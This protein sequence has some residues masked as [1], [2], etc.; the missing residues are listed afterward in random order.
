[1]QKIIDADN[2]ADAAA[3]ITP[4]RRI[5]AEKEVFNLDE[6]RANASRFPQPQDALL[7]ITAPIAGQ[8]DSPGFPRGCCGERTHVSLLASMY[9]ESAWWM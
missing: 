6:A 8:A 5:R 9:L 7:A 2:H 1:M 4:D 3:R